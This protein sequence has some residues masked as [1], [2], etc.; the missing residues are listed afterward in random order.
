MKSKYLPVLSVAGSDCSG[1]AGIQADIKT[2]SAL[3][4][5]AETVITAITAQNTTGVKSIMGVDAYIV[6]DQLEMIF[7]DIP[8]LAVKT[9]ML[10]SEEI[11]DTV[12]NFFQSRK[13]NNLVVDPVMI[14]TSGSKLLSDGAIAKIVEKLLPISYLVTP[15][16]PEAEAIT[17]EKEVLA[18]I[19]R[20]RE[21]GCRNILIKGGHSNDVERKI[22]YLALQDTPRIIELKADAIDTI[23]THGTGCTLSSAIA[24][25]LAMGMDLAKAVNCAKT[26][27]TQALFAGKSVECGRG[28]G[29]VNHLFAPQ[30]MKLMKYEDNN[31]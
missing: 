22:D 27:I 18:Q 11:V 2:I 13:V 25:Y 8:P 5:Y 19:E 23:N 10:Y 24:S 26:Y 9:G 7:N 12:V 31:K 28:H 17:G 20:F 4:C 21:L 14:S 16:R 3:G 15:N 30:K 1:G 6:A 29:P